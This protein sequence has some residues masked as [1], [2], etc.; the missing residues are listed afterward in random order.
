MLILLSFNH[1]HVNILCLFRS[2][3][4]FDRLTLVTYS[5]EQIYPISIQIC[6]NDSSLSKLNQ[7]CFYICRICQEVKGMK[8]ELIQLK[9][10][11]STQ[12]RLI[13]DLAY[14]M[15][16]DLLS[17]EHIELIIKEPVFA[18]ESPQNMLEAHTIDVSETLDTLLSEY[19]L[20]DALTILEMEAET[21]LKMQVEESY[22]PD[23][24]MSYNSAMSERKALLVDQL[25]LVAKNPRVAASEL[26]K[27]LVGLCRLGH[28]HY[29]TQLL[30]KYYQ[31]R[32]E[33]G[34]HSFQHSKSLL[35]GAN[36]RPLAKFVFSMI[37]QA[38][39]SFVVLYGETSPYA[40]ELIQW[41]GEETKVFVSCF[42]KFAT[43][44]SE[45]SGGLSTAVEAVQFVLSYCSLL[46]TQRL[47][48]RSCFIE[49]VRPCME[50]VLQIHI[51][52]FKKFVAFFAASD[53]WDLGRYLVSGILNDG[54][55][56][57][58][59][60]QQPEYCLLTNSGRKFV[61]LLQV[62]PQII[63][64]EVPMF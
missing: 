54:G 58:A 59:I 56:S 33:T 14:G 34:I 26:Q 25:I 12:K 47:S 2:V 28:S 52:H 22:P 6:H 60:G 17:E 42:V 35:H 48:L 57:M 46:E 45:I 29:A 24:L 62:W 63:L 30:L 8:N 43:S 9:H 50:E 13:K 21:F 23:I 10:Y 55:S 27:A 1:F 37:S 61:I 31:T 18:G 64:L 3:I 44:I 15:Y 36:I 16:F 4:L 11:V 38:A 41:A 53:A 49:H 32:L 40:S 19:R 51:E 39:K 20:D 7:I 5:L